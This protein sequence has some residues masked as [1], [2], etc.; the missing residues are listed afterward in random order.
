MHDLASAHD[1]AD[2]RA[3]GLQLHR[4]GGLYLDGLRNLAKEELE[5]DLIAFRNVDSQAGYGGRTEPL[6]GYLDAIGARGDR[7][8]RVMAGRVCGRCLRDA[9]A[10]VGQGYG[11]A[12]DDS[13][14]GIGNR[15]Q[16]G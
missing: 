11:C 13:A 3:G 4:G 1:V 2:L 14:A 10:G 7:R 6:H 5:I 15:P 12:A 16:H 9:G 8:E